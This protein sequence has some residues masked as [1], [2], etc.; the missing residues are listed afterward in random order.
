M[1]KIKDLIYIFLFV[2]LFGLIL[3]KNRKVENFSN[4]N[5]NEMEKS[6]QSAVSKKY[7]VD[8]EAIR[9]L[10][11]VATKLQEGKLTIPGNLKITG[12]LDVAGKLDVNKK[13]TLKNELQINQ[14]KT[15]AN[16]SGWGTHFNYLNKG[17]NYI[18]GN[19]MTKDKVIVEHELQGN[20]YIKAQNFKASGNV[21]ADHWIQG[22]H[23]KSLKDSWVDGK[24]TT[25]NLKVNDHTST[26]RLDIVN[27]S[28]SNGG[29]H[30]NYLN[31]GTNYLRGKQSYFDAHNWM[32]T[33]L[34]DNKTYNSNQAAT[35]MKNNGGDSDYYLGF[36]R[37][38]HNTR[39]QNGF[40]TKGWHNRNEGYFRG[41]WDQAS[42][43]W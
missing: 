12:N 25:G 29:T 10:S 43:P 33:G 3:R 2:I 31:K 9:N 15:A 14:Q 26:K 34:P 32:R 37:A 20:G 40:V 24:L 7:L 42:Q 13:V 36:M 1:L 21:Y 23:L 30:F 38:N 6:I 18:R 8:L 17:E 41:G 22:K 4:M 35:Y 27:P 5:K 11:T 28:G 16:P 19:L 39:Y